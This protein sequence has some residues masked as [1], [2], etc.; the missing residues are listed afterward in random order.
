[1]STATF[2]VGIDLG[3]SDHALCVLD[4][5]RSGP[6]VRRYP[7][8]FSLIDAVR[9]ATGTVRPEDVHVAV[10][11]RNNVVVDELMRLGFKVFTVNPKQVDRFRDRRSV[12]G[13]KDDCRDAQVLA[14]AL[15]TDT[16]L[17]TAVVEESTEQALV[18]ALSSSLASL[19]EERGF[20]TN[21]LYSVVQR[22]FPALLSLCDGADEAWFWALVLRLGG[23]ESAQKVRRST[24]EKLLKTHRRR[25]VTADDVMA[26]V[27]DRHMRAASG[28][29]AGCLQKA[30]CLVTRLAVVDEEQTA[31]QKELNALLAELA[32]P[33]VDGEASD[34]ALLM[35][36][37]GF[38]P[39]TVATMFGGSSLQMLHNGELERLRTTSGTAPVTKQS[40]NRS[41]VLMR[42]ACRNDL[43]NACF[44]AANTAARTGRFKAKYDLLRERG[45]NHARA[46]RGIADLLLKVLVAVFKSRK[47]F[48][49][50]VGLTAPTS[51]A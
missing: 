8:S 25:K 51:A 19:K 35:S 21:Q 39:A 46:L 34:V 24:I 44:H 13:A 33:T 30:R 26:V 12:A 31:K 36:M 5:D 9:G 11:D 1:M 49:A 23:V 47:L 15:A 29:E 38:G 2:F 22:Y 43:R 50:E 7:N 48:D 37:P 41:Q 27:H 42:Y 6:K 20:L 4:R 16:P 45:H 17:F 40:G 3:N 18:A 10:E 14:N 28:V 32:K